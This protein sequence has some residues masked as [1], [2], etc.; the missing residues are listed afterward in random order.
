VPEPAHALGMRVSRQLLTPPLLILLAVPSFARPV[1]VQLLQAQKLSEQGQP[2]TAIAILEPLVQAESHVLDDANLG[3]A[4][5]LLGSAY[6][7]FEN[8]DKARR[9]YENA[10]HILRSIPSEQGQYAL[11]L[12]NLGSVESSTGHLEESK[13]LR[14][15]ARRLY[16]AAGNHAAQDFA[17]TAAQGKDVI[18]LQQEGERSH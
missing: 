11:A 5:D 9:C 17:R 2:R 12:D 1:S 4:W 10:I 8:Y 16:E 7:D 3:I 14:F 13:T 15:K 18:Q 6:Q